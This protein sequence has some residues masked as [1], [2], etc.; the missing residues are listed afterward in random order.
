MI[1]GSN[2]LSVLLGDGNGEF[3][4]EDHSV[5]DNRISSPNSIVSGHFNDDDKIDL[6][7]A[8]KGTKKVYIL[9]GQGDGT[10]TTGDEYGGI[11]EPSALATG[12]FNRDG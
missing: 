3:Q 8:N 9:Y 7:I 12:D 5:D 4:I 11:N 2:H 6:A 10:F 1:T